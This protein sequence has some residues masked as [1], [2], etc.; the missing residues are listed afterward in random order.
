MLIYLLF[1]T[2]SLITIYFL[3]ALY[4]YQEAC[5]ANYQCDSSKNLSC[6]TSAGQCNCPTS[7]TA[8]K[9]DCSNGYYWDSTSSQ[10]CN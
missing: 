10:C 5:A 1:R 8:Y 4:S 2:Y 6:P 9:C 3:V 7:S